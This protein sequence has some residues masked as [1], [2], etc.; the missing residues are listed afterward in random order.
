MPYIFAVIAA[1][2]FLLKL[3]KVEIGD[4]DL[5]VL[6]LFFTAV[7][8]AVAGSPIRVWGSRNN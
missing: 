7:H 4:V 3:V 2:I 1:V 5:V 8:L 6:G